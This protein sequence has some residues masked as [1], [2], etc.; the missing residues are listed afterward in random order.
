MK[1]IRLYE[2]FLNESAPSGNSYLLF[3]G[4]KLSWMDNGKEVKSWDAVSGRT[5]YHLYINPSIW[6]KRQKISH[7]E[8][9]KAKN[10]G[11]TP[12]GNYTLGAEQYAPGDT[13]KNAEKAQLVLAKTT[14]SSEDPNFGKKYPDEPHEF[15]DKTDI[16]RVAWGNYRYLLIPSKGTNTFGRTN[17]YIHGGSTPGSI[18]CIDLTVNSGDFA[19]YYKEWRNANKKSTIK[20]VVDYS[21]FNPD[22]NIDQPN[23]PFK[24]ADPKVQKDPTSWTANK[25]KF[26]SD[27]LKKNKI[28]VPKS[29]T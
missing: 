14:A 5:P 28:E 29:F 20:L 16:A 1:Y 15:K 18:G 23:Q 19:K 17:F 22:V 12:P 21:T 27:T 6:T 13:W 25:K 11:P 26:V 10:E 7:P 2:N 9:S 24:F 4:N 8:W 3:N